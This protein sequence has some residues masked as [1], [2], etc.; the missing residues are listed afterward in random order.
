MARDEKKVI[1]NTELKLRCGDPLI[2]Y[3]IV[4]RLLLSVLRSNLPAQF[5]GEDAVDGLRLSQGGLSDGP[6]EVRTLRLRPLRNQMLQLFRLACK[7]VT[8]TGE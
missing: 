1:E 2:V 3:R 7:V 4:A 6:T 8:S 5:R